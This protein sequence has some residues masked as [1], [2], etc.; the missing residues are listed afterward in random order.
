[1]SSG[2]APPL[3]GGQIPDFRA[4][5]EAHASYVCQVVRRLGVPERDVE[6]VSHDVFIAVQRRLPDF[7]ATRPIRAWLFGIAFRVATAHR[8]RR[9]N[10]HQIMETLPEPVDEA[11]APDERLEAEQKRRIFL[12]ALDALDDERRAVFVLHEI[13]GVVMPEVAEALGI[14][15]NTAYSRLRLA[16]EDFVTAARRL[17]KQ[18]R[19]P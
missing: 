13:D 16:R 8:R 2:L 1:M 5:F 12:R 15:L 11:P 7:D 14:P 3:P 4:V 19:V 9:S 6:D 18:G 17:V 10:Q